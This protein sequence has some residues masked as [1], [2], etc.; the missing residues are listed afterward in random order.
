MRALHE[1]EGPPLPASSRQGKCEL[2][3]LQSVTL[4]ISQISMLPARLYAGR[5]LRELRAARAIRQAD[6]AAKLGI[7]A[8]YLSQI[9]HD[10]RPLTPALLDRLLGLFPLVW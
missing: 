6:F 10:D 3:K 4:Q 9:E 7:S 2:A 1:I 5:Q 8:S